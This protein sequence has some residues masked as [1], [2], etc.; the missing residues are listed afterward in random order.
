MLSVPDIG[1]RCAFKTELS[2]VY[3]QYARLPPSPGSEAGNSKQS[4]ELGP[5]LVALPERG[6]SIL[7]LGG[8]PIDVWPRLLRA[9]IDLDPDPTTV[10]SI[11][12]AEAR[13]LKHVGL[14]GERLVEVEFASPEP[15]NDTSAGSR[16][17]ASLWRR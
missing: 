2:Y 9:L 14:D 15:R 6:D 4:A 17:G 16:S 13:Q 11:E 10:S 7:A 12:E 8:K 3:G 5:E 1:L